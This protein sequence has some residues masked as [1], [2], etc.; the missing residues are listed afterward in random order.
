MLARLRGETRAVARRI[1]GMA[2]FFP[3]NDRKHRHV[4]KTTRRTRVGNYSLMKDRATKPRCLFFVLKYPRDIY[5]RRHVRHSAGAR[6]GSADSSLMEYDESSSSSAGRRVS[7][8]IATRVISRVQML[9]NPLAD[10]HATVN[11]PSP[12]SGSGNNRIRRFHRRPSPKIVFA[13]SSSLTTRFSPLESTSIHPSD[14]CS[15]S[16]TLREWRCRVRTDTR[17]RH[18]ND[19]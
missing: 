12:G 19:P 8:A 17:A 1:G 3:A 4:A 9:E 14:C 18:A 13:I 16:S 10:T 6:R 11:L 2:S 15:I 5:A 7:C